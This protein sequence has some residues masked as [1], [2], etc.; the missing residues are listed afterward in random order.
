MGSP[1]SQRALRAARRGHTP[2]N[3]RAVRRDHFRA[4][5][6]RQAQK[7][8]KAQN[9]D[10]QY[11]IGGRQGARHG[12]KVEQTL[13][14]RLGGRV[15]GG[16]G[17]KADIQEP[18]GQRHSVKS[19]RRSQHSRL[20]AKSYS[21]CPQMYPELV[22]YYQARINGDSVAEQAAA[23][24]IAEQYN[25]GDRSKEVLS[26]LVT[27]N[28]PSLT[29]FTVYQNHSEN[30]EDNSSQPFRSY[31]APRAA[32][33][34]GNTLHYQAEFGRNHWNINAR[35]P[36]F[37]KIA[38]Q[39]SLGSPNRRLVLFTLRN[40]PEQLQFWERHGHVPCVEIY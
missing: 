29:R 33:Y 20:E 7:A 4:V 34:L 35:L 2:R 23:E 24:K 5:L 18:S 12:L 30:P 40:V 8:Q 10:N 17:G 15:I 14:Q 27:G 6:E 13:A 22:P 19:H 36:G 39:I 25:T 37:D 32:N 31:D 16:R 28:D 38:F 11:Q 26:H 21:T 3:A 9:T 1:L